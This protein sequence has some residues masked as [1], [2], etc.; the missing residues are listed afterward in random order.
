M[1]T[2]DRLS[3]VLACLGLLAATAGQAQPVDRPDTGILTNKLYTPDWDGICAEGTQLGAGCD[4][5]RARE[6]VDAAASPWRAIG[7]VNYASTRIRG[8]CTGTLVGERVV[9]TAAHCLYNAARKSWVPA[10]SLLF[11][12]GYQRGGFEA[13]SRVDR[14]VLDQGQ[15]P[16]GPDFSD[17]PT[18]DWALLIL[19]EPLGR[20][21]GT[22]APRGIDSTDLWHTDLA[23][24]GYPAL[25]EHVLSV[26]EDCGGDDLVLG[27]RFLLQQCPVMRGDS[28]GPVL[29]VEEGRLSLVAVLSGV[30]RDGT[31][32]V[33]GSVPV[34]VFA[35][36]LRR[37]LDPGAL[38]DEIVP[39]PPAAE[40]LPAGD[41][42][43]PPAPPTAQGR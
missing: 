43:V 19:A 24:A 11:A 26:E 7:R 27:G 35:D 38:P 33:S 10:Q 36:A 3:R 41:A 37:E 25:R 13:I 17:D 23:F 30:I 12:A 6:I 42:A 22:L 16:T 4:A 39:L 31:A 21:L 18:A 9:A 1:F 8:H 28:G 34:A 15:D 29:A 5:I 2:I 32:L 14:Y 20:D 40:P